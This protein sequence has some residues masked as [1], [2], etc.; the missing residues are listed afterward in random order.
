MKKL[1]VFL[2]T[3]S[4]A[5]VLV[6]CGNCGSDEPDPQG[7]QQGNEPNV[8]TITYVL[9]LDGATIENTTQSVSKGETYELYV[10]D[11]EGTGYVFVGWYIQGTQTKFENGVYDLETDVVL[12]AEWDIDYNSDA[13][14]GEFV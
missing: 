13:G 4:L 11:G 1:I 2:L 6:S 7:G 14:W 3:L 10:P 12:V 8:F 9:N 5:L